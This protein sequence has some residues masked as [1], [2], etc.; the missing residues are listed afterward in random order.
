MKTNTKT[1]TSRFRKSERQNE[2][3]LKKLKRILEEM[4]PIEAVECFM[5]EVMRP[6]QALVDY[7]IKPS[8]LT[9][10]EV[11]RKAGMPEQDLNEIIEDKLP[12]TREIASRFERS[13]GW[14]AHAF[15][16]FQT[17]YDIEAQI[18]GHFQFLGDF[19][20]HLMGQEIFLSWLK[21]RFKELKRDRAFVKKLIRA[22]LQSR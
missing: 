11:A 19:K 14:P 4:R 5:T 17:L 18:L 16:E 21:A 2:K 20:M 1:K 13:L 9:L 8:G 12:I 6:G 7:F 3:L 10:D 15:I 22:T